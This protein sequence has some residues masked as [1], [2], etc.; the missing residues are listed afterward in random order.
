MSRKRFRWPCAEPV[1][2]VATTI[3]AMA[4]PKVTATETFTKG[5][6]NYRIAGRIALAA[7][8]RIDV[9]TDRDAGARISDYAREFYE[10]DA[11]ASSILDVAWQVIHERSETEPARTVEDATERLQTILGDMEDFIL[12][13][14]RIEE[15][16]R[17]IARDMRLMAA[18]KLPRRTAVAARNG[19]STRAPLHAS[20]SDAQVPA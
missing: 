16:M 19:R 15:I 13:D 14:A 12:C 7:V 4:R 11:V 8:P 17:V 1:D 5:S 6:E 3:V 2:V 18:G 9:F 10:D 20:R